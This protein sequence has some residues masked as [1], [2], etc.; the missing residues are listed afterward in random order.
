MNMGLIILKKGFF[1]L[2]KWF[3]VFVTL[4]GVD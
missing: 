2:S 3:N 4:L 1:Y